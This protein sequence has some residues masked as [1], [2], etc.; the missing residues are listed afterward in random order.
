[1]SRESPKDHLSGGADFFDRLDE[2]LA[3]NGLVRYAMQ[4]DS[5]A[6]ARFASLSLPVI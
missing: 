5:I 4:P 3:A 1:M 2:R 6:A